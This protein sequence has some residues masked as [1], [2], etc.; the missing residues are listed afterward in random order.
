M[1]KNHPENA[2]DRLIS[3]ITSY[4]PLNVHPQFLYMI[5]DL[6]YA[7]GILGMPLTP[8]FM[9]QCFSRGLKR[10]DH[11]TLTNKDPELLV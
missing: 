1:D 5:P 6:N 7:N 2:V 3:D 4:L 8:S 10:S 9:A 11:E